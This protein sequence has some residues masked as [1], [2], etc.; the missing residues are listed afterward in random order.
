MKILVA[1]DS[2]TTRTLIMSALQKMDHEVIEAASGQEALHLFET[3]HPDLIIL[4]VV[5][6][7]IDGFECARRIRKIHREEWIPIIFLSG[8]VDDENIANGIDAGG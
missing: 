2:K 5:M 6:E 1:D 4:D 7:G 3:Q 8:T